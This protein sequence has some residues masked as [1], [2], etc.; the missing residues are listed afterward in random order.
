VAVLSVALAAAR[1]LDPGRAALI[2]VLHDLAESVTGDLTPAE[3][4]ELGSERLDRLEREALD[5]VLG[6]APGRVR[7]TILRAL[8]EYRDGSSEEGRLVRDVDKLEM[9]LQALLYR[10][11]LG[12]SGVAEFVSSALRE[13]SDPEIRSLIEEVVG[14]GP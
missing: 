14:D 6:G 1:G 10:D 11:Q 7:E 13:V 2:A 12:D 4:A 9:A 8:R 5:R 3:K